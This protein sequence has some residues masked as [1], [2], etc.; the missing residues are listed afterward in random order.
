L[1]VKIL[2]W[3]FGIV[4]HCLSILAATLNFGI[5]DGIVCEKLALFGSEMHCTRV[6]S[7]RKSWQRDAFTSE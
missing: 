3:D 6:F 4:W 5:V 1:A 2:V 7:A